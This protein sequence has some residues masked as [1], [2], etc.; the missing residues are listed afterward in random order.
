MEGRN[1]TEN[2]KVVLPGLNATTNEIND[3]VVLIKDLEP[4]E[5]NDL[6]KALTLA[7]LIFK[8]EK[9]ENGNGPGDGGDGSRAGEK[10]A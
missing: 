9:G 10:I 7:K 6:I 1:A 3:L 5:K 2:Q 8:K 4:E